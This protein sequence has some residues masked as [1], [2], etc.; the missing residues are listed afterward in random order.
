MPKGLRTLRFSF[1]DGHLTHL[2]GMVLRQR[3][4]N[5]LRLRETNVVKLPKHYHYEREFVSAAKA[6]AS[7]RLQRKN[8]FC[9]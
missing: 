2:G 8:R 1:T 4:C 9:K 3:F 6:A 5:R 7:L